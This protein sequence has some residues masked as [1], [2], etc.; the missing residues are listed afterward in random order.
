[1]AI[2]I[3]A[4]KLIFDG[5]EFKKGDVTASKNLDIKR[6]SDDGIP[7]KRLRAFESASTFIDLNSTAGRTKTKGTALD[8]FVKNNFEAFHID[9]AVISRETL[10]RARVSLFE[11]AL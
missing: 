9:P 8:I 1:M 4:D 3:S 5:E 6:K 2:T 7:V 10:S 11:P